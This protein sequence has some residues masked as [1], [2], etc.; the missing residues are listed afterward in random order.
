MKVI[1]QV[2]GVKTK[3]EIEVEQLPFNFIG[4]LSLLKKINPEIDLKQ[5]ITFCINGKPFNQ[6]SSNIEFPLQ[7]SDK[8][9][10]VV[11]IKPNPIQTHNRFEE[12]VIST[13]E[14]YVGFGTENNIH[15][16]SIGDVE[17][18][19][20]FV[21]KNRLGVESGVSLT[22]SS[23]SQILDSQGNPIKISVQTI[24][25][26]SKIGEYSNVTKE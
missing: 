22:F 11:F 7:K 25:G 18:T 10:V 14:G 16:N 23:G 21:P 15:T 24:K 9:H 5:N 26:A 8:Y 17:N 6:T 1:F 2:F 12:N 19:T 13:V 4:L 20:K 3:N